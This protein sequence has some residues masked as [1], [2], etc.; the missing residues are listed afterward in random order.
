[1][2]S[3]VIT[4]AI[5]AAAFLLLTGCGAAKKAQQTEKSPVE[6][7]VMPGNE[8][9]SGGGVIRAMGIGRSDNESVARKKAMAEA[10]AELAA[11]LQRVVNST[12][13]SYVT[14]LSEGMSSDSKTLFT[15]KTRVTVDQ[16]LKG[17][18]IVYD[19]WNKDE[20]TGMF[21]NYIVM[22]LNGEDYLNLLYEE[23]G[24]EAQSVDKDELNEYFLK[25]IE[26]EGKKN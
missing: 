16:P 24:K 17:A 8:Y 23:L 4:A 2:K 5:L 3:R 19:R 7:F 20:K 15:S 1:M 13:D 9:L 22:A 10:S 18:V 14:D 6:T 26:S 11:A 12:V 25:F 21:T